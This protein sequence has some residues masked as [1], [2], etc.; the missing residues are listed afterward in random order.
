MGIWSMQTWTAMQFPISMLG[1]TEDLRAAKCKVSSSPWVA[2]LRVRKKTNKQKQPH[3]GEPNHTA[4][5]DS[6]PIFW[7]ALGLLE[8]KLAGI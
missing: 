5:P 1:R 2:Q 7:V 6:G 8:G 3:P 4:Q